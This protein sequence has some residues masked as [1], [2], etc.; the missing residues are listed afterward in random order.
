M[1]NVLSLIFIMLGMIFI[2]PEMKALPL[3]S[4]SE[5]VQHNDNISN[6]L[7]YIVADANFAYEVTTKATLD[8][9]TIVDLD[10]TTKPNFNI[11]ASIHEVCNKTKG[12]NDLGAVGK[13]VYLNCECLNKNKNSRLKKETKT[14][15]L[16]HS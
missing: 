5:G 14:L 7:V 15:Y 3:N 6:S 10:A 2:M 9:I 8:R 13:Q 1:R 4:G 16:H 12:G 11:F